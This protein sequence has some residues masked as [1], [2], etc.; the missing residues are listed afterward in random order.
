MAQR[1]WPFPA[2]WFQ[3]AHPHK[4]WRLGVKYNYPGTGDAMASALVVRWPDSGGESVRN[5][6]VF[7]NNTAAEITG[8]ADGDVSQHHGVFDLAAAT[9]THARRKD[10]VRYTPTLDYTAR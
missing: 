5:H 3:P 10:A 7:L 1:Q 9:D 2:V 8:T 6:E 4:A